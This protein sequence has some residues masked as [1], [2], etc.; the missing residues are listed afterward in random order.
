[1]LMSRIRDTYREITG[2]IE[3]ATSV[4]MVPAQRPAANAG[5]I[6]KSDMQA[7]RQRRDRRMG[8][9]GLRNISGWTVRSW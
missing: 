9:P 8:Q 6:S 2:Y 3:P 5:N 1:M 7:R 4:T